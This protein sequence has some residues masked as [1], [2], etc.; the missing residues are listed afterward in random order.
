MEL[1]HKCN[2]CRYRSEHQ[3]MGFRPFGVCT[4]ETNLIE[5]EKA[6]KAEVCPYRYKRKCPFCGE[7]CEGTP[8][9]NL[10]CKCGAKYYYE[11]DIWKDRKTGKE[12]L[13]DIWHKQ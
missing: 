13:G 8:L 2:G 12:V 11:S 9:V 7:I 10:I 3:E 6:Y 4:R 1:N 5:A